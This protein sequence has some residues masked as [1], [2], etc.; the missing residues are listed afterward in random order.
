MSGTLGPRTVKPPLRKGGENFS[1]WKEALE[2]VL[3]ESTMHKYHL[4]DFIGDNPP[5]QPPDTLPLTIRE[6]VFTPKTSRAGS[7]RNRPLE[8]K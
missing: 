7:P 4:I 6:R 2:D 5:L 3:R 1:I 8:G